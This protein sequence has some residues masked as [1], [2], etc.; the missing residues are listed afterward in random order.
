[1]PASVHPKAVLVAAK[2]PEV[3]ATAFDASLD[4][5][6]R[7]VT[8]LGYSVVARIS[9][10]RSHLAPAAVLGEGKLQELAELTEVLQTA[11]SQGA[12]RLGGGEPG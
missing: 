7:L 6:A 4:E 10:A 8:T 9:Q 11:Q 2:L 1:M 3:D 5:L 12:R